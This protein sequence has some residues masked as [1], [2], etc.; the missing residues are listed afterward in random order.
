MYAER[1]PPHDIN[2]E[3]AVLGSVLID[4]NIWTQVEPLLDGS[5]F[6]RERNCTVYAAM[7]A[8]FEA[9]TAINSVTVA[10]E[11]NRMGELDDVG[12][13][14]YLSHIQAVVPTPLHAKEYAQIIRGCAIRRRKIQ[15][16][17]EIASAAYDE[18]DDA[19]AIEQLLASSGETPDRGFRSLK[20]VGGAMLNDWDEWLAG[21]AKPHG[22]LTG[23]K[24]IDGAL[25]GFGPGRMYVIAGRPGMGKSDLAMTIFQRVA[26]QNC[27]PGYVSLEMPDSD[28]LR[29]M[30]FARTGLDR[31]AMPQGPNEDEA[32]RLWQ[33]WTEIQEL[34]LYILDT[35]GLTTSEIR[36]EAL[37][38]RRRVGRLD[39]LIVDHMGHAEDEPSEN[40]YQRMTAIS[41]RILAL[42][43]TLDIPVIAVS[44]LS[45]AVEMRPGKHIPQLSDL[46]DS[47]TIEQDAYAVLMLWRYDYYHEEEGKRRGSLFNE[48]DPKEKNV[49]HVYI[50]KNRG[51]PKGRTRLFY[52]TASGRIRNLSREEEP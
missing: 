44:Q 36:A 23:L 51:G 21:Q 50:R 3:E 46:R 32:K 10:H 8:L 22:L 1:L 35:P 28:V 29:R 20:D 34:G 7:R 30:A 40:L 48:D 33:A 38:L 31:H 13:L 16:A 17:G 41:R 43:K 45:R 37:D 26:E 15:L 4:Q 52:D 47:G 5:S 18:Q 39:M 2:A 27:I 14:A 49:L 11:L 42:A 6:Y 9:G 12:G 19:Q 25:D 24:G